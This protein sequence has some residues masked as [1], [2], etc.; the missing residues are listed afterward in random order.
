MEVNMASEVAQ[1][2]QQQAAEEE[3]GY[4]A[5]YGPASVANHESIVARTQQG[6]ETLA[7]LFKDGRDEEAYALWEA[8]IWE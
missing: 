6:A 3:A 1:F 7:Q 5:L 4:L 2:R 8:G